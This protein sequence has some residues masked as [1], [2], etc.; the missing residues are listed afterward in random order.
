MDVTYDNR[1]RTMIACVLIVITVIAT[2]FIYVYP[3]RSYYSQKQEEK[4]ERER[5]AV[6]V[7]ANAKMKEERKSLSTDEKIEEIA[8]E[9][10]RLVKPGEEAYIVSGQEPTVSTAP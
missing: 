2:L 3:I 9:Q 6:L 8:R 7:E 10:Y 1:K 4:I 5:L